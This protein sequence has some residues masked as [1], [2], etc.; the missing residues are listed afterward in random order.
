MRRAVALAT[1][2]WVC[3]SLIPGSAAAHSLVRPAGAVVSYL[4]ADATSLNTLQLRA[5]GNRIEFRDET[6]DGGMDPGNCTPG[7][8]DG[9]GYIIQTFCPLSGV[10]RVRVDLG[11][12]EDRATITVPVATTVLAGPGAD[13]VA[14][15]PAGDELSGGEGNDTLD[16]GAGDDVLSGDQG[17][18]ALAGGPGSDRIASR[19]GEADSVTCADGTDSV[20]ADTVDRVA[21]D[22]ENVT[23]TATSAPDAGADDG[24]PPRLEVGAPTLQRL[25]RSSAVRVY[26]TSSERGAVSASGGLEIGSLVLPVKTI[27]RERIRVGGGGAVLTY[28]LRGRHWREAS[29]ALRRGRHVVLRLGVVAT[30]R[31]GQ[32]TPPQRATDPAGRRRPPVGGGHCGPRRR[33]PS[34]ARRRGR[35]RGSRPVRQLRD[36]EERQ[37]AGHRWRRGGRRLR[38][39]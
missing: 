36:G 14:S 25:A 30:D 17:A 8:L 29:R 11:E 13:S 2:L 32:T 35:R 4:S 38:R 20:D 18:D 15:G 37:P 10:Q 12:R 39:R 33:R 23:R 9:N 5:S 24:R 1:A 22:C 6:V 16:G 28:R 31:A 34:R 27:D 3:G 19:D 7:D 21:A 26:A